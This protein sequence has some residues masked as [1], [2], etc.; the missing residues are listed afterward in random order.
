MGSFLVLFAVFSLLWPNSQ[1]RSLIFK[2]ENAYCEKNGFNFCIEEL[3]IVGKPVSC[4]WK[5]PLPPIPHIIQ[6]VMA[7]TVYCPP[8]PYFIKKNLYPT[9]SLYRAGALS[10]LGGPSCNPTRELRSQIFSL[11]N[12]KYFPLQS[13]TGKMHLLFL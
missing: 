4:W 13:L 1:N 2:A 8:V 10:R 9:T 3:R 5:S 11:Y 6:P 7:E 12:M